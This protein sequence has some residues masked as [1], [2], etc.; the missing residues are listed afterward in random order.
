[1][2][3]HVTIEAIVD[4]RAALQEGRLENNI[5]LMD[6]ENHAGSRGGG[7]GNLTTCISNG[8]LIDGSQAED[9]VIN[10]FVSG[11]ENVPISLPRFFMHHYRQKRLE[12]IWHH[13]IENRNNGEA[14]PEHLPLPE[15]MGNCWKSNSMLALD[16]DGEEFDSFMPILADITGE[17]V[18]KGIIYP[19]RYGT[20]VPVDEGWYWSA[21]VDAHVPGIYTYTMHIDLYKLQE[22]ESKPARMKCEAYIEVSAIPQQNGFTDAGIGLLPMYNVCEKEW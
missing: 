15:R 6:S 13:L 10:W 11:M 5:Y 16:N 1:M 14:V 3:K 19:A 20:P 17:A 4:A 8:I 12:R 7:S 22:K 21:S 18:E 9:V 2:S